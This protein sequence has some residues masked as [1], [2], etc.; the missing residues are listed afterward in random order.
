MKTLPRTMWN[1]AK[2]QTTKLR[3]PEKDAF[4]LPSGD[5]ERSFAPESRGTGVVF[6]HL[7]DSP[8]DAIEEQ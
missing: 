4:S 7:P 8:K 1:C 2:G 5:C 3:R 6:L